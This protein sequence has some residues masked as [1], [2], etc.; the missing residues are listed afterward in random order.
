MVAPLIQIGVP[1]AAGLL[2]GLMRGKGPGQVQQT[3]PA[4]VN[5][6]GPQTQPEGGP[7]INPSV[8]AGGA[9]APGSSGIGQGLL[10][11][12]MAL[13]QLA[14]TGQLDR[15]FGSK[16]SAGALQSA[17][18]QQTKAGLPPFTQSIIAPHL[19]F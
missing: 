12:G 16:G 10:G 19:P 14:A 13:G 1:I 2:S 5:I 9:I 6:A 3:G 4:N 15:L 17:I 7:T 11:A 8:S 18:T